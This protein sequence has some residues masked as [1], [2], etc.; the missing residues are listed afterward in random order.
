[1]AATS[2]SLKS[3]NAQPWVEELGGYRLTGE[4]DFV[5]PSD[6][7]IAAKGRVVIAR[8]PG[9]VQ[10]VYGLAGVLGP[11][12]GNLSNEGGTLRL[13]KPSDAIVQEV[14]WNDHAPWPIAPDGTG[15]SLVLARPSYGEGNPCAWDAVHRAAV[16]PGAGDVAPSAPQDALVINGSRPFGSAAGRFRRAA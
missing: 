6:T 16:L 10:A 8:V 14:S 3:T 9:D 12:T 1:M 15:H 5:F 11:F 13:R 7:M 4:V 2:S